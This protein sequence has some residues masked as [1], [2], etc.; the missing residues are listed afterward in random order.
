MHDLLSQNLAFYQ[1]PPA[2][3]ASSAHSS[4]AD[5]WARYV[6]EEKTTR[7]SSE[8][9]ELWSCARI[10]WLAESAVGRWKRRE[11]N[12]VVHGPMWRWGGRCAHDDKIIAWLFYQSV[13]STVYFPKWG[14]FST[15]QSKFCICIL[16]SGKNSGNW[17][18][19]EEYQTH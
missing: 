11:R 17:Q 19:E 3:R 16:I 8:F 14:C 1:D 12:A 13:A 5:P 15:H 9:S 18:I 4:V 7:H 10:M 6:E 2:S